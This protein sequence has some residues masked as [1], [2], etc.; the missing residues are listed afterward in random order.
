[1]SYPFQPG[2]V[3]L[4]R[5]GVAGGATAAAT[6]R[7]HHPVPW[8]RLRA[9]LRE[10]CPDRDR[11]KALC[12]AVRRTLDELRVGINFDH[13]DEVYA[14]FFDNERRYLGHF[15]RVYRLVHRLR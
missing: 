3:V 7:H 9:D 5:T 1:M 11:R 10:R 15:E 8:K 12:A 4:K 2:Q 6:A 14:Q 13:L